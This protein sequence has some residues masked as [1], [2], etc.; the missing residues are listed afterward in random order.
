MAIESS[1]NRL[2][3]IT[4]GSLIVTLGII[5]GD[6]GTSPLYVFK[7]IIG[8]KKITEELVYGGIS[9]VIW[10]L[11]LQ[12]TFKYVLLTLRADNKGEGGIF[13]LYALVRRSA[14]WLYLP[15]IIGAATL[16]A[17]GIIM[18]SIS[19]SSAI[20]GLH[21]IHGLENIIVPGNAVAISIVIAIISVLFFLQRF[22]TKVVGFSF[23]PIMF[24]WFS[25]IMILGIIQITHSPHILRA[26]NPY[27]GIELLTMYPNGF[28]VLGAV[29]LCTTGA[30]ALYSDLG[31]CGRKNIQI[32]WGFV[33][34]ALIFNYMGQGAWL[35]AQSSDY[36][37]VNINPFYALMPHWFL[38]I[39]IFI[40]IAATV[41]ASQALISSSFTLI[42][43]A[44]SM[45]F[46][47]RVTVKFPVDIKGQIYIP[48]L[49]TILWV[50]CLSSILYFKQSSQMEAA[51][52]FS[53]VI[54][55]LMTTSLMSVY[56]R[57]V[58]K[59]N[60]LL[61]I[62]LMMI[63]MVLEVSFFVA[64]VAKLKQSWMFLLFGAG[65]LFFVMIIVFKA[66]KI[67]NR[68][69]QFVRIK[70]YLSTI[71][72]LSEDSYLPKYATHLVYLTK[73]N[74][75]V[76]IEKRI[77]D[78][79]ICRKPKRADV[80][81]FIHIERADNPYDMEYAVTK[82]LEGKIM[83][84]DFKLGFRAQPRVNILFKKVMQDM[85]NNKELDFLNK[86]QSAE[87]RD[88]HANISYIIIETFLSIENELSLREGFIMESYF[89]IKN[90]AQ[91][92]QKAFG[93]DNASTIMEYV[94]LLIMPKNYLPL[95]RVN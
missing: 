91:S 1:H 79:I 83:R 36:L 18:P 43:E 77:I 67:T 81:W 54:T 21:S 57:Y 95:K 49:N 44:I 87:V 9:C 34:V 5:Y 82:I 28:W 89:A 26:M 90:F 17:D 71:K 55:M 38:F 41:I 29:F 48:S 85:M 20:E 4:I 10:T 24:I 42:S 76:D 40:A 27:Y 15:A 53:I 7:S 70:D 47:P 69:L 75:K 56:M 64:Q 68:Y 63:F 92:D 60:R 31:H 39:G 22:G 72:D 73:S 66:R 6:I 45:N 35:L 32:S 86:A 78:S 25:M 61:V 93:L 52:G 50:G 62:L 12:T 8:D 14:K 58:K 2:N 51:Y 46:W 94:P 37:P 23:G 3:K 11:T 30:E 65:S 80:Y 59:W 16:I 84:I 13:S 33:K 19:V 88:F 74:S